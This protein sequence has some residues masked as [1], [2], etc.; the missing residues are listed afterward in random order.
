M[1]KA[2]YS[3]QMTPEKWAKLRH[4][5]LVFVSPTLAILF[6]QLAVG[7]DW[8]VAAPLALFALYQAL[9][10]YFAKKAKESRS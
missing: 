3:G 6:A 9:S 2:N 4:N 1:V 8:K 5:L 7:V 10:D